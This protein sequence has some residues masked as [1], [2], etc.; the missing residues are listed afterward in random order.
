M[1]A[2]PGRVTNNRC[3]VIV[4]YHHPASVALDDKGNVL[5][6][7]PAFHRNDVYVMEY[8]GDLWRFV[9]KNAQG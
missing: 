9:S 5:E 7:V 8:T 1:Q 2:V 3:D 4:N 6:D